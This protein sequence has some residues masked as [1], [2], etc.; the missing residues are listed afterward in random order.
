MIYSSMHDADITA[1][2]AEL[3][4]MALSADDSY[5]LEEA[6]EYSQNCPSARSSLF[7]MINTGIEMRWYPVTRM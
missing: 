4:Y 3:G 6:R 1:E 2:V 5:T 7:A